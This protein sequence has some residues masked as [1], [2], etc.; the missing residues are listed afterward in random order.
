MKNTEYE[1]ISVGIVDTCEV[2][3]GRDIY[4]KCLVCDDVLSSVPKDSASCTCGNVGID[5]DMNRLW[6]GD[7]EKFAIL[8]RISRHSGHRIP[9]DNSADHDSHRHC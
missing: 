7:Y 6:V 3:R 4:Y 9:C 1:T 2:S 8:R 5:K